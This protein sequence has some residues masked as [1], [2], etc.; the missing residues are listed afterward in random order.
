MNFPF[1]N[2]LFLIPAM[3]GV[4][5]IIGGFIMLKFPPLKINSLY[6]YRTSNSMKSQER[7]HFAQ[8]YASIEMMKLGGFLTLTALLGLIFKP[9][10]KLGMIV[11][12]GLMLI[13]VIFLWIRVEK[14]IKDKFK[15]E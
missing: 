15:N 10:G 13:M 7:W 8:K 2:P 6:G 12:L 11:G 14:A 1:D 3:T 4:I 5:F 9:K